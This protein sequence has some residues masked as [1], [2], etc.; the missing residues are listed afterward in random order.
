MRKKAK[1]KT[2]AKKFTAVSLF[3]GAGGLDL[4]FERAGFKIIWANDMNPDARATHRNWSGAEVVP[5]DIARINIDE[6]PDSD[7]ILHCQQLRLQI[8]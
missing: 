7:V 3:C 2:S 1:I 5:G 8:Y 4:G 6:I